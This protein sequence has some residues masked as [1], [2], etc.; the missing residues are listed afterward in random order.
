MGREPGW[1]TPRWRAGR[2]GWAGPGASL[3]QRLAPFADSN[4]GLGQRA[5]E[6]ELWAGWESMESGEGLRPPTA[7]WVPVGRHSLS[8][9]LTLRTY[10]VEM[11]V[12]LR[13]AVWTEHNSDCGGS[14][15][16]PGKMQASILPLRKQRNGGGGGGRQRCPQA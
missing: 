12:L 5:R 14:P 15:L 4:P 11:T 6:R 1:D 3:G 16:W 2:T 7:G 10:K 13:I 8:L 9:N